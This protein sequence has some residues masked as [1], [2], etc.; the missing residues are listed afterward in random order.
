MTL[1]PTTDRRHPLNPSSPSTDKRFIRVFLLRQII[2]SVFEQ[3]A[4][5]TCVIG[6]GNLRSLPPLLPDENT[7]LEDLQ[8]VDWE[9]EVRCNESVQSGGFNVGNLT[10]KVGGTCPSSQPK[11]HYFPLGFHCARTVSTPS[12]NLTSF[13]T[14]ACT[15][16]SHSHRSLDRSTWHS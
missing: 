10:V 6:E 7:Q 4:W 14:S 15:P 5:R 11:L 8:T 12:Q 9:G 2:V 13:R 16:Y 3:R 1:P